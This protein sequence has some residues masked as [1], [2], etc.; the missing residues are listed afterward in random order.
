MRSA[1]LLQ[2]WSI[3]LNPAIDRGV[4][5]VQTSFEHHL[6]HVTIAEPHTADTNGHTAT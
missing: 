1:A 6:L 2:L 5:D 3:S 4:I